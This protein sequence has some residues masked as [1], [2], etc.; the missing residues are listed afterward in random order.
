M[1]YKHFN[2]ER[3]VE[4]VV[5]Q[6]VLAE[7]G[8]AGLGLVV[9]AFLA[10]FASPGCLES[11]ADLGVGEADHSGLVE[12]VNDLAVEAVAVDGHRLEVALVEEGADQAGHVILS[13]LQGEE[14]GRLVRLADTRLLGNQ[15]P[16]EVHRLLGQATD[17]GD[18]YLPAGPHGRAAEGFVVR[19][20]QRALGHE[21]Q[22]RLGADAGV[23]QVEETPDSSGGL[24][25]AGR[26]FE[27]DLALDGALD[28]R[29]LV[30]GKGERG[31]IG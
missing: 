13:R 11:L 12:V 30:V 15:W 23:E 10:V 26:A 22:D 1:V 2:L 27:E 19:R 5:S 4:Q 6:A 24:A 16:E 31:H 7:A 20:G 3:E 8:G 18:C 25:R 17:G 9:D 29:K 28:E 14:S 21:H